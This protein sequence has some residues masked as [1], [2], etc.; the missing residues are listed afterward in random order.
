MLLLGLD[1]LVYGWFYGWWIIG[2]FEKIVAIQEKAVTCATSGIYE[3]KLD[4]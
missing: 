2:A 1:A 3:S 4:S